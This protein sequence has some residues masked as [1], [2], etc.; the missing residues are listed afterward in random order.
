MKFS[1]SIKTVLSIVTLAALAACGGGGGGSTPPSG[2]QAG[3][4]EQAPTEPTYFTDTVAAN[5]TAVAGNYA[6]ANRALAFD[7]LN[8]IRREAGLGAL[9]QSSVIDVAAQ[10][11]AD[12]LSL[13]DYSGHYQVV[14]TPGFTGQT[15]EARNIAAGYANYLTEVQATISV[16]EPGDVYV[17]ALVTAPYHRLAMLYYRADEAGIGYNAEYPSNVVINIGRRPGQG[18]PS[19]LAVAWPV[20]GAT[21]VRPDGAPESPNPMPENNGSPYGNAI[22]LSTHELKTLVVT[23]FTLEDQFGST[24]STKLLD[25]ATDDNLRSYNARHFASIIPRAP[26][27]SGKTYVAKFTGTIDGTLYTKQW[28]FTTR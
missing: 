28:S 24:V 21:N 25:Y 9:R 1:S 16:A 6:D 13:N 15:P 10:G 22:S 5:T 4:P 2:G 11:H 12:W 3:L 23:S 27:E 20:D 14:G 17:D 7:R 8:S 18:A 26:L 19:T